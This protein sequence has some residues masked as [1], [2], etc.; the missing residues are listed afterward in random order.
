[1]YPM[2]LP[3]LNVPVFVPR[4]ARVNNLKRVNELTVDVTPLLRVEGTRQFMYAPDKEPNQLASAVWL[5]G[6]INLVHLKKDMHFLGDTETTFINMIPPETDVTSIY[7]LVKALDAVGREHK[8]RFSLSKL[9][10]WTD[11]LLAIM[12]GYTVIVGG[13]EYESFKEAELTG[14]VPMPKPGEALLNGHVF[15]VIA[16]DQNK[17]MALA[18]GNR[19]MKTGKRGQF[20]YRGSYLRNLSIC[21][22]FFVVMPRVDHASDTR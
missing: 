21:R 17:D 22:D 3:N 1:M 9:N 4:M 16:F 14:I 8:L 10:K 6:V 7:A 15:N 5:S 2:Q 13:T 11:L 20:Q 18:I 12:E 19:G